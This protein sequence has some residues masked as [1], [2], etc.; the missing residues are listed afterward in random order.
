MY[1]EATNNRRWEHK[2]GEREREISIQKCKLLYAFLSSLS[3]AMAWQ[4]SHFSFHLSL[5][6]STTKCWPL[7]QSDWLSVYTAYWQHHL[8]QHF[9]QFNQVGSMRDDA[10]EWSSAAS[11]VYSSW[12]WPLCFNW[13]QIRFP[14][15]C[16]NW[17]TKWMAEDINIFF[18]P[19]L[20][21]I[22]HC[23]QRYF[24]N[25]LQTNKH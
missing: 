23:Q 5:C 16:W 3:T 25:P 1:N 18:S 6:D 13:F 4:S 12:C 7:L 9:Y 19:A 11:Q 14:T 20:I 24:I 2:Q 15:I 17:V 10:S 8:L 22:I 21:I